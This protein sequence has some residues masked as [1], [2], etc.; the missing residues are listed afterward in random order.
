MWL[1]IIVAIA[2]VFGIS[3]FRASLRPSKFPPGPTNYP[4]FG[5]L[6]R[7]DVKNLSSSFGKLGA[8]YGNIFSLFVGRTPV[9]VLNSFELIKT[10]FARPEFSGRPGNFSGT[11]FQKGNTGIT[12][13][14]GKHWKIQ[15]EFLT[16]YLDTLT[17]ARVKSFEDVVMDEVAEF[18]RE[19]AKKEGEALSL[20]YKLNVGILNVLWNMTC[21]RKLH[22]QQQEF[23]AVYECIDKMTT[24]MSKAAIF[25]FLPILSK[26]LPESITS[27][28]RGRYY[29][30][31]FHEITEKWI[32]EHRQDYRGNRTGD[33]QDAYLER[34]NRGE[35]TFSA[36]GLAAIVREVFIIG[37]ESV[38]VMMRWAIRILAC[39]P[40]VQA[41]IQSE[42][43]KVA[44]RGKEVT[45]EMAED[46]PYTRAVIK[47]IQRFA[48]VV[49]TGLMH[50]TVCDVSI[51]GYELPQGTLVMANLRGCHKDPRFWSK[52]EE[53]NPK[54]FL[55]EEGKVI[56]DKEG[57][58]P[59][60]VGRRI[61]PGA[62]LADIQVFL[63]VTNI[64]SDYSLALPQGDKGD[65]GTQFK[66]GTALLRNP[67]PYRVV[68]QTRA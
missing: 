34:I 12:T 54:H 55:T 42:A 26:I 46:M 31:R 2:F 18:K 4:I 5:S 15:R 61:C 1:Q 50:K 51:E 48:D 17:G 22:S 3:I 43:D 23:Q 49:P 39:N 28:E 41:G 14:E 33:L 44:G 27:M 19:F 24:F 38:S 8:K 7:L 57:F 13:T 30:N 32:R 21:G 58:L 35:E 65:L 68:V 37:S 20:S 6:L 40:K 64:L 11:F 60:G 25:S 53:F 56:E 62:K 59:Y 45:W 36:E 29:R 66:A 9:V 63:M 10:T 16:T 47:E 67:K 52:P